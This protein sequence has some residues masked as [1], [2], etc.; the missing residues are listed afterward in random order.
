MCDILEKRVKIEVVAT[1]I[2][3]FYNGTKVLSDDAQWGLEKDHCV[4]NYVPPHAGVFYSKSLKDF[5]CHVYMYA[6]AVDWVKGWR[7][8]QEQNVY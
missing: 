5:A 2:A 6:A 3:Q 7:L 1:I 4:G 8:D